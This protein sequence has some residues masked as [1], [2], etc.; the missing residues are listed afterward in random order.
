M[1]ILHSYFSQNIRRVIMSSGTK[2]LGV[3]C[4]KYDYKCIQSSQVENLK[5]RDHYQNAGT[6]GRII[7]KWIQK[8]HD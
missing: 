6:A 7:L 1:R 4:V 3:P 8:K 5:G 2:Q